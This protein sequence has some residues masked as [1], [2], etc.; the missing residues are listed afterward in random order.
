MSAKVRAG[1]DLERRKEALCNDD[2]A[3]VV[4]VG[5]VLFVLELLSSIARSFVFCMTAEVAEVAVA[6]T[7]V[8]ELADEPGSIRLLGSF[9][10]RSSS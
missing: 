5:A 9:T 7:K 6:A 2:L 1:T 8:A 10:A 4:A 3:L